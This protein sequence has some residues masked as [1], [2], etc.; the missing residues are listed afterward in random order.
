MFRSLAVSLVAFSSVAHAQSYPE[1][2]VGTART[3]KA[4]RVSLTPDGPWLPTPLPA[5]NPVA[6]YDDTTTRPRFGDFVDGARLLF[7]IERDALQSIALAGALLLPTETSKPAADPSRTIGFWPETGT[8]AEVLTPAKNGLVMV[9]FSTEDLDATGFVAPS[10]IGT[11]NRFG[12]VAS[13]PAF[14]PDEMLPKSFVLLDKPKG[15]AFLRMHAQDPQPVKVLQRSGAFA[16]VRIEHDAVGWVDAKLL[17]KPSSEDVLGEEGGEVG[18]VAGGV[19][20]GMASTITLPERTPLFDRIDGAFI[21]VASFFTA[22]AVETKGDWK[23][24]VLTSPFGD[25]SVW[26]SS[27]KGPE[28][29]PKTIPP[30]MLEANRIAGDKAIVPDDETKTEM[31]RAHKDKVIGTF[32]VC[33]DSA[34]TIREVRMLKS[35]GFSPYDEKIMSG[36]RAWKYKPYI[37][38][39]KAVPVCTA[40]T[41]IYSQK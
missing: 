20:G 28:P 41:F 12:A 35:T 3:A 10:M 40:V 25:I 39:G 16:L 30:K 26:S 31:M 37:A 7:Y 27:K 2:P 8:P 32:K 24:Y 6:I 36:I 17:K 15:T 1:L 23:R 19:V 4:A 5:K 22:K 38:D 29:A 34:G 21:G 13:R 33:L 18:G 14:T 11:T 9:R